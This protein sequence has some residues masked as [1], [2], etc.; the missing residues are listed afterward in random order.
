VPG[1]DKAGA[2]TISGKTGDVILI[3][4]YWAYVWS[5]QTQSW[6]FHTPHVLNT[7]C[8]DDGSFSRVVCPG[9]KSGELLAF[10]SGL[11]FALVLLCFFFAPPISEKASNGLV[12]LKRAVKMMLCVLLSLFLAWSCYGYMDG[13]LTIPGND[14]HPRDLMSISISVLVICA[15]QIFG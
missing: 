7:T 6:V 12:Q 1:S 15:A 3:S 11:V 2:R 14:M 13:V 10:R 8:L 4:C 5:K 9:G